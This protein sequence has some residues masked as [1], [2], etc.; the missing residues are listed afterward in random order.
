MFVKY[1]KRVVNFSFIWG[2]GN[3]NFSGRQIGNIRKN[4]RIM[5]KFFQWRN[6]EK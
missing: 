2:S 3:D 6:Q 5:V 1:N 4:L